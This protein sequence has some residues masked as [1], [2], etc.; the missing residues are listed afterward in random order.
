MACSGSVVSEG[1]TDLIDL[2][3]A[4][5]S[6]TANPF[7]QQHTTDDLIDLSKAEGSNVSNEQHT[8]VSASDMPS[9]PL[10]DL[11]TLQ[12]VDGT[13]DS[14]GISRLILENPRKS[15]TLFPCLLCQVEFQYIYIVRY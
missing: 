10:F 9:S 7:Y 14:H 2:T 1:G 5:Q 4:E 11:L 8:T 3:E 15:F 13:Q 12:P 6:L